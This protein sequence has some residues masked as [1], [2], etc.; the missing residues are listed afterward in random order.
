MA[1]RHIIDFFIL[2]VMGLLGSSVKGVF[3]HAFKKL[4]WLCEVI[5]VGRFTR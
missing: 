2:M 4:P 1:F 5:Q 3:P